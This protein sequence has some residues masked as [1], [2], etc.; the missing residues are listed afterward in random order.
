MGCVPEHPFDNSY[1][2]YDLVRPVTNRNCQKGVP[3]G[4]VP[5]HPFDN[6][7]LCVDLARRAALGT[8]HQGVPGHCV[9]K[10]IG[11]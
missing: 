7:H 4:C 3:C 11:H 9:V 6:S 2:L 1:L 5:E 10:T 8:C